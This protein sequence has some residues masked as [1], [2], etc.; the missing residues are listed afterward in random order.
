[1]H[2]TRSVVQAQTGS[3]PNQHQAL[4]PAVPR[5]TDCTPTTWRTR[6]SR[7][8]ANRSHPELGIRTRATVFTS[9]ENRSA[10]ANNMPSITFGIDPKVIGGVTT[11][12]RYQR[13][14][15]HLRSAV[16]SALGGDGVQPTQAGAG[17][18]PLL[19]ATAMGDPCLVS[20]S[21]AALCEPTQGNDVPNVGK[22]CRCSIS[23][24][25][26]TRM[27]PSHALQTAPL[28][29]PTAVLPLGDRC[30]WA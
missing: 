23:L 24:P 22:C 27:S 18:R 15:L 21:G 1:M 9:G 25:S 4:R 17:R 20:S 14:P 19:V 26:R 30:R 8:P 10:S 3:T 28:C 6:P 12:L 13:Q 11:P 16:A 7:R 2:R 5:M 29:R